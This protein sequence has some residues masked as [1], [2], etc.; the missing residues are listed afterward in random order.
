LDVAPAAPNPAPA[1]TFLGLGVDYWGGMIGGALSGALIAGVT[2]AIA[3]Q[4]LLPPPAG[5]VMGGLA[6]LIVGAV[7]GAFRG[8]EF[9]GGRGTFYNGLWAGIEAGNTWEAAVYGAMAP[10]GVSALRWAGNGLR[11]GWIWL[12]A[13]GGQAG[14]NFSQRFQGMTNFEINQAIGNQQRAL[15]Q[16]WMGRGAEGARQAMGCP[17][18]QGLTVETLRAYH[19]MARRQIEAGLDTVLT[20]AARLRLIEEALRSLGQ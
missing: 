14:F 6:G 7:Y 4:F 16:Q 13:G 17:L 19:E 1:A 11:A 20:Q 9:G 3:G 8:Y 15:L 5:W 12:T 18:P 2:G 10:I